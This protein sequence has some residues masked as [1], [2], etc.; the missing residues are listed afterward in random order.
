VNSLSVCL[1]LLWGADPSTTGSALYQFSPKLDAAIRAQSPTPVYDP[2]ASGP[3]LEAPVADGFAPAGGDPYSSFGVDPYSNFGV[4]PMSDPYSMGGDP[5][6]SGFGAPTGPLFTGVNGPQPFRFGYIPKLEMGYIPETDIDQFPADIEMFELDAELRNNRP[7]ATGWVLSTAPQFDYRAWNFSGDLGSTYRTNV[8]RFGY[9]VNIL[10]IKSSG[11]TWDFD[12]N[13]SINTDTESNLTSDAWNFDA[14]IA[15]TYQIDP[16]WLL[17]LG[18]QYW[19]R[20]D[21]VIIPHAGVVFTPNDV[22]EF[23]LT[24]P[25]ARISR[26]VGYFWGGHHW[27]YA[28]HEYNVEAYQVDVTSLGSSPSNQLQ[29]EDFRLAL[30][31]RSDHINFEKFIEVAYVYDRNF[32]F[33]NDIPKFDAGDQVLVRGG[34]R[35]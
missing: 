31:L 10:K 35:F 6:I 23:R 30:G 7:F 14:R 1:L 22:W 4:P 21:D 20:V 27:L 17:V 18:V 16:R 28:S 11:W 3:V 12:F 5:A 8:Y 24:F 15:A 25:K 32:E 9:D 29:Y 34:I 2:F 19:D 13:P 33:L 26:F